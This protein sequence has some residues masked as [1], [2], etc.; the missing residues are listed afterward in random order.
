MIHP[1]FDELFEQQFIT[2]DANEKE[3]EKRIQAVIC[4]ETKTYLFEN[5]FG[6]IQ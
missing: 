1:N 2:F 5:D 3:V 6:F 4:S